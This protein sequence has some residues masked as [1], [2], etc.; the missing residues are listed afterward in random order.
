MKLHLR[1]DEVASQ[2]RRSCISEKKDEVGVLENHILDEVASQEEEEMKLHLKKKKK[3]T[4]NIKKREMKLRL[5][6]S[7]PR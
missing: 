7:H 4:Q 5:R 6:K 2:K 3:K 1:K